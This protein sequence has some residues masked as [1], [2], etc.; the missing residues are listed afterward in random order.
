[1]KLSNKINQWH[2]KGSCIAVAAMV[3]KMFGMVA[4]FS[5]NKDGE[6]GVVAAVAEEV[7]FTPGERY[8]RVLD[9]QP[10]GYWPA[11]NAEADVVRDLSSTG[12]HGVIHHVPWDEQ[13]K[14]LN[15]TGAYQW[16]EIPK[17]PAYQTPAFSMGG[18]VFMR[19]EVIGSGWVNRQGL[20]LIGNR[21]PPW[22][23]Q[24]DSGVQ[25]AIRRQEVIDVMSDG[26]EDVLA[27]RMWVDRRNG[28]FIR[29]SE[30]EPNLPIGKWQHLLYSFE[31]DSSLSKG[32]NFIGTGSLYLNGVLIATK[33]DI[34]Y[35]PADLNLQ[36]GNDAWWWMQ[37][38]EKSGSLDGSVRDMVWFDRVLS[39]SEANQ[40]HAATIPAVAPDV[41]DDSV[42]I[43]D[44]RPIT[45][46]DLTSLPQTTRRTALA[47]FNRKDQATLLPLADALLPA[48][49]AA[50]DEPNCRLQSVNLLRKLDNDAANAVLQLA[51][52][53]LLAVVQD[54]AKSQ[55]ERADAALGKTAGDTV[56]TLADILDKLV[57]DAGVQP[58]RVEELLRNALT[59]TLLDIGQDHEQAQQVLGR[60][61]AKPML[62]ALDLHNSQL[63]NDTRFGELHSMIEAG[64]YMEAIR[65]YRQF[66]ATVRERFFTF[67]TDRDYTGIAYFNGST[68]KVGTGIAWQGVEKVSPDDF[69]SVV[70]ELVEQYPDAANWRSPDYEHLYRVP[71]TKITADGNEHKV[72]LEGKNFILDG[73]D[74]KCRG[75]SIFVDELGYIHLMGGQHNTPNGDYYIP[76]SW[77]KLGLSRVRNSNDFPLQMYWVSDKPGC[78]ESFQFVGHRDNPQAIPAH[79]LNYMVL[80]Q[81]LTNE[82]YL[83]GRVDAFGWQSW[84][85]FRYDCAEKQWQTVGGDVYDLVESARRH[86]PS[87]LNYLHNNIRGSIPLRPSEPRP[88]VWAWQPPFYNFCRDGWGVRFDKTGRLHVRMQISGL[89]GAGYV[90]PTSVYAWS[91]DR[92]DTFYRADG[93]RVY[94]PLTVNPAPEHNAEIAMDNTLQHH[95][96]GQFLTRQW[97]NLWLGL[98]DEAGFK[99]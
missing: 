67:K 23:W 63:V 80:Q 56:P 14:L 49:T 11:D 78:I 15:F 19:S 18:W 57:A 55:A 70:A 8:Q 66:P 20:L 48:L 90:R 52:T 72:Y 45:V 27:T 60:T 3:M 68:F 34:S 75:W 6:A 93:S 81:S 79:Y 41:Y 25:L 12:N 61:F 91:D 30:G 35:Q 36:I 84:G 92:G 54:Q 83:Y 59:K 62:K 64:Q 74:E 29:R 76:G 71:I 10:V 40:L 39:E 37:T 97:L 87:W 46:E 58:P 86:D 22:R 26:K 9:L 69:I 98:L 24:P 82:T 17:H 21:R 28:Q 77:E 96:G 53:K 47:L 43:L 89:D 88:L 95:D 2:G 31:P 42:V 7:A 33:T 38:N 13:Q 99:D 85:M 32:N 50:L 65:I 1:M 5:G 73:E 51:L 4:C 16:L 94:L 44:G